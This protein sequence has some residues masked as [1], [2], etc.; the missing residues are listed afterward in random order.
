MRRM[1]KFERQT[2][3]I[4][5]LDPVGTEFETKMM[6]K[7]DKM[8][9]LLIVLV[10]LNVQMSG[11]IRVRRQ[12]DR[13]PVHERLVSEDDYE[14]E[15]EAIRVEAKPQAPYWLKPVMMERQVYAE[16]LNSQ[17]FYFDFFNTYVIGCSYLRL[18]NI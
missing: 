15:E 17:V 1:S 7:T 3:K 11:T 2:K 8:K 12:D 5:G 13:D 16:V 14:D 18:N 10:V 6:S 4:W 9:Y